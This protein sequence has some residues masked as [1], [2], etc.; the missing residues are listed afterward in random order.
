MARAAGNTTP[1]SLTGRQAVP[2][3]LA[4]MAGAVSTVLFHPLIGLPLAAAALAALVYGGR[5]WASLAACIA[6]GAMA[7]L[8]ASVTVYVV[9]FP[10]VGVATTLRAPYIY[11]GMVIAELILVGPVVARTMRRRPALETTVVVT[12]ALT[13][14]QVAALAVLAAG[15]GQ[16]TS[17]YL[18]AAVQSL[19]AQAGMAEE[20]AETVISMW[21]GAL[22]T[23]NG[24]TAMLVIVG[25]GVVGTR[26]GIVLRRVPALATLDLDARTVVLP[27]V[28]IA[29]LAAGRL[30]VAIAPTL[31]V[32]GKNLLVV[33]RWVFFL[34]G[35]A[36]FA[37][38][39]ERRK[40]A[41]PIRA[42]GFMLLGVTEAFVPL[43]SLT[44]L[45]DIWLN[46][47]RLPRDAA[48]SGLPGATPDEH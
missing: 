16:G 15:A 2:L 21:P 20:V 29:L 48:T 40:I 28:A 47:R 33:A 6:G 5:T 46:L 9:G 12:A 19:A 24:L 38:L 3:V 45:A 26:F 42:L 11:T 27:I 35:I 22:V 7:G 39:Y 31:D 18:T 36:A 43:V 37:G 41:R 10:L 34:Q 44:G 14:L 8:L 4:A 23:V 13:A 1:V 30:P 25:V 17:E 32:M